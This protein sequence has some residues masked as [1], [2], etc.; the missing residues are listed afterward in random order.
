MKLL[1]VSA[2]VFGITLLAAIPAFATPGVLLDLNG[3][4]YTFPVGG[5]D[6]AAPNNYYEALGEVVDWDHG[7]LTLNNATHQITFYIL[8]D[9]IATADTFANTLIFTYLPSS[10][11]FIV[12][13][14]IGGGTAYDYG[15]NPQNA[16]APATFVDGNIV[17]QGTIPDLTVVVDLNTLDGSISGTIDWNAGSQLGALG[18]NTSSGFGVIGTDTPGVPTGYVWD[19]DGQTNTTF[20]TE[21]DSWGELKGLFR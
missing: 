3:F 21:E 17:L 7:V 11:I 8:S 2:A 16:T 15:I 18:A 10:T 5:G 1:K 19:I 4:D 6:F 13:D 12:E 9:F 14:P 20:A